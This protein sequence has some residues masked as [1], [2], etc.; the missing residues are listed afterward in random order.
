[1]EQNKY[2]HNVTA[3]MWMN[4]IGFVICIALTAISIV[5]FLYSGY[6]PKF[7]LALISVL[8]FSQAMVQLFRIQPTDG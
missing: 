2:L 1:M 7:L 5:G 8:A 6:S 3:G 4:V